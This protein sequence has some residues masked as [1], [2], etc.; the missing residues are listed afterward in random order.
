M[1]VDADREPAYPA[2]S[3]LD[4][5]VANRLLQNVQQTTFIPL[6][7]GVSSD[8]WKITTDGRIFVVKRAREKLRVAQDWRAP[9]SRSRSEVE[10]FI[11]AGRIVPG[12]APTVIAS[13]SRAGIVAMNY[14]HPVEYPN[15]K[16]ELWAGRVSPDFAS[17]VGSMLALIHAST[18]G[19]SELT[20]RVNDDQVF[21]ALR[22]EPYLEATAQVNQDVSQSLLE[23]AA[24]VLE[25]KRA[26]VHGDVSPKNILV[27]NRGPVFLDAECAWYGEPA[28][29][30]AFCLN[31]LLLKCLIVPLRHESLLACFDCLARH[32]FDN[33]GWEP[34]ESLEARVSRL[35]PALLLARVDGKSPVEYLSNEDD[36][37]RVRR[38]AKRFIVEPSA[39]LSTIGMAW[40]EELQ[41]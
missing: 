34:K 18:A 21:K 3:I 37:I 15:W 19:L 24:S 35:L 40:Q 13:D 20:G 33:V 26:L 28:F 1:V 36:K 12:A 5:L 16:D 32:Y 7:G 29:D 30:L 17:K 9:T 11:E 8:I 39:R 22:I 2:Q 10:W 31:H 27:G 23:I 41:H 38:F 4:F 14:F 6:A 25:N